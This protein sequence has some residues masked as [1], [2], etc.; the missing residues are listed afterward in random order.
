MRVHLRAGDELRSGGHV[1]NVIADSFARHFKFLKNMNNARALF[2][3]VLHYDRRL[4]GLFIRESHTFRMD[5]FQSDIWH[6]CLSDLHTSRVD[7][8]NSK[9]ADLESFL[10]RARS[11]APSK[12]NDS[13][14]G[15]SSQHQRT[16]CLSC[17]GTDHRIASCRA[18]PKFLRRDGRL[19]KTPEGS[20]ICFA[21]NSF[22][23]CP[24]RTDCKYAHICSLC[25]ASAHGAQSCTA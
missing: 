9:L 16:R 8:L 6:E 2:P 19:W 4:R 11:S 25:G 12:R 14:A 22:S 21:F 13:S 18:T 10:T 15:T 23:L 5:T 3:V 1:A 24:R 17:G 20:S 7:T